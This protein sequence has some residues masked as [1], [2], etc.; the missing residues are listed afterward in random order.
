MSP[1][2]EGRQRP[3]VHP[4]RTV[5]VDHHL[6]AKRAIPFYDGRMLREADLA[7]L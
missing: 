4:R 3:A 5:A 6:A 7:L 2:N 1:L